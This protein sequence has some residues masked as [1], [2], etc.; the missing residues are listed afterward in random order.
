M[1]RRAD[2]AGAYRGPADCVARTVRAEG[3]LALYKGFM[4][5]YGRQAP[6]NVLNYVLMEWLLDV[7][8]RR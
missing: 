7:A 3:V 5:V 8:R 4:P 2:D 1:A 6:F